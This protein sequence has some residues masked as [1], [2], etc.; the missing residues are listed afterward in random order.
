MREDLKVLLICL[1]AGLVTFCVVWSLLIL[2]YGSGQSEQDLSESEH[3][4]AGSALPGATERKEALEK[5][6]KI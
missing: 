5:K 1:S 4:Q 2:R 3:E 6:R